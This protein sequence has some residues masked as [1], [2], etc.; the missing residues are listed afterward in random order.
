M[1]SSAHVFQIS[2]IKT[3]TKKRKLI[4][5]IQL[6][7]GNYIGGSVYEQA[8]TH[9]IVPQV[10]ASEKFLSACA[11]GKW[12]VTPEY[13][14]DSVKHGSWLAE[15][16]YEI[17]LFPGTPSAFYP[18]RQWREK[19]DK[20]SLEGAFHNWRVL[21]M[22]KDPSC[23]ATFERMLKAGG[24][25]VYPFPPPPDAEITHVM[26]KPVTENTK[27][28]NAP[29]YPLSYIAQHLFG[30]HYMNFYKDDDEL[31]ETKRAKCLNVSFFE[32]ESELREYID[33]REGQ[34]RPVFLEFLGLRDPHHPHS[35][36]IVADF[37]N[38]A[39]MIECGLFCEALDSIRSELFPCVLPPAPYMVSLLEFA[40]QGN[41]TPV[42]LR[43]FQEVLHIL[44]MINPPW[45]SPST[46]KKYFTQVLQCPQCKKGLWSFIESATSYCQSSKDTCHPLPGQTTPAL[47]QF[48]SGLLA[49][50][51]KLFQAELHTITVGDFLPPGGA[52]VTQLSAS[53]SLLHST[54]WTVWEWS[55]LLSRTVKQLTQV[56]VQAL[57]WEQATMEDYTERRARQ[58]LR[59]AGTVIGMLSAAVEFWCQQ[60][61]KLNQN[62]V[63]KGWK[64]LAEHFALISQDVSPMVL[65]ELVSRITPTRL[66][67]EMADAIFRNLCCRS[68]IVLGDEPLSLKKLVSSYL[69]ALGSLSG[70]LRRTDLRDL[71]PGAEPISHCCASQGTSSGIQT[72][73]ISI[74]R[75]VKEN[76][77]RGLNRVN[78]A[79]ETLLHRACKRNQ[80][81]TVLQILALPDI[82]INIK[83]H[84]GWT[85]L[86][87]ACNHGSAACV[88]A[89][90]K[91]HSAPL[92]SKVGGV[93]P[94]HDAVLCG[95]MDIAKML[96]E[97]GG[98]VLLQQ[99]DN[100]GRSALDLL[101]AT[102][103]EELLK[104]AQV[105][106]SSL[107]ERVSEIRDLPL[108]EAC[109]SLLAHIFSYHCERGLFGRTHPDDKVLSLGRKL[110]RALETNS[111]QRMTSGWTDQRA[112]RL[113]EDVEA[114]VGLGRGK[115]LGL[116]SQAV[117][118]C[119][120]ENTRS[121]ME[122]LENLKA[123][124]AAL[125]AD[126]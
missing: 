81:E 117:R 85:P 51:L 29:C 5:G 112:V 50:V 66:R 47:L 57:V 58:E 19:L 2:G 55:T 39:C 28:H 109:S 118:E 124:G 9:I 13:V 37:T 93:T 103:R 43:N 116:V 18:V 59:L 15:E 120:G 64:D 71:R 107:E 110:A 96:L 63:E 123:Q 89:L 36:I 114:L 74:T 53:D 86:H 70:S 105:G 101:S 1:A 46:V 10:L 121:L 126:L 65:V 62:L 35:Q 106:D 26:A 90:L 11:A 56:L 75:Q 80:V 40:V 31:P 91:H 34:T 38:V 87:E 94:L 4:H 3:C 52:G 99:T 7:G 88:E 12:V 108:L 16:P 98:S 69:P 113:L 42:F 8:C 97:H 125:L 79:G 49:F 44:I 27:A 17:A 54:F 115:Y 60:H 25:K 119:E 6:L 104:S 23:W 32:L 33:R 22:V 73:S 72:G 20:G 21:L 84:A 14:L 122:I 68:G 92:F 77:P 48:F 30:D 83:D 111:L 41:A 102:Q 78:A 24:A 76:L 67:L 95:H 61:L 45:Q 82:D 100:V